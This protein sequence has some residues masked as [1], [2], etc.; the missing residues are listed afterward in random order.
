MI[1]KYSH[2]LFRSLN[3]DTLHQHAQKHR[4]RPIDAPPPL[5]SPLVAV[6]SFSIAFYGSVDCTVQNL[7]DFTI[8]VP[9]GGRF[10][11]STNNSQSVGGVAA[12]S[13]TVLPVS[14]GKFAYTFY[15]PV[16]SSPN[17]PTIIITPFYFI[18][19]CL[20][21]S[22][23]AG[24]RDDANRRRPAEPSP[25][26]AQPRASRSCRRRRRSRRRRSGS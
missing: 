8:S 9:G 11:I 19:V 2:L 23:S 7:I 10:H 3:G 21:P 4:R 13:S 16:H 1:I 22:G 18:R 17:R 5:P 15:K 25:N 6:V 26:S 14:H 24:E 20:S 12:V